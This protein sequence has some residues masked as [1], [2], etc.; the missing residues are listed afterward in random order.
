MQLIQKRHEDIFR[1]RTARSRAAVAGALLMALSWA[2]SVEAQSSKNVVYAVTYFDLAPQSIAHGAHIL[3]DFGNKSRDEKGNVEFAV[4]Q[5]TS[6]PDRFVVFE[7]WR[8]N[9]DFEAHSK[10]EA[11]TKFLAAI[12]SDAIAPPL[13]MA[14]FRSYATKPVRGTPGRDSIYMVEHMDFWPP[15]TSE[16]E[17][18]VKSL[19]EGAQKANETLRYDAYQWRGHHYTIVGIWQ[20]AKAFEASEAAGFTREF[21]KGSEVPGGRIDLYDERLYKP[22][23]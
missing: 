17:P 2:S 10:A 7:G 9:S 20:N 15:F 19:A 16:A 5:E 6:R 8:D 12:K 13:Q 3:K 4:L 23:E 18:L 1:S 22:V 21:R 11:T 14:P